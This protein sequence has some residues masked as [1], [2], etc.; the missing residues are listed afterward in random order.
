MKGETEMTQCDKCSG[1]ACGDECDGRSH[2]TTDKMTNEKDRVSVDSRIREALESV[3]PYFED[4]L[5]HDEWLKA[6]PK[7]KHCPTCGLFVADFEA[8]RALL[9]AEPEPCEDAVEV[10][11][12]ILVGIQDELGI[13][14][15]D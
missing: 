11:D 13:E 3:Q 10:C 8:I 2:A 7:A 15:S 12:K 9:T 1:L 5:F 6:H 14:I 4:P